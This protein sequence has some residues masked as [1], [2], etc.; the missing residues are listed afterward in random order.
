MA[1][2][3]KKAA[4]YN[5]LFGI[6]ENMTGEIINGEL[7]VA[8]RPS[9]RHVYASTPP[10]WIGEVLSPGTAKIDKTGKMSIYAQH[11]VPYLWFIDP[12]AKSLDAFQLENGK[13]LVVGL[14]VGSD[15]IRVAPFEE[16][17]IDLN[18]L[19]LD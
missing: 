12:L 17:E 1:G 9:R 8:P 15:K 16:A 11:N 4:T 7:I 6:P 19:W 3:A 2:P 10:D 18:A 5:D 14:F 13:W